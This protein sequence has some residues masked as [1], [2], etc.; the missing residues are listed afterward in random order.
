[1]PAGAALVDPLRQRAHLG[2]AIGDLV[3]EQHAAAAGLC[4]LADHHLDR[5]RLAQVVGVHAVARRKQL[6]HELRRVP[7]LLRRHAAVAGRRRGADL[8][9]S[10]P[11]RLLGGRRERAEAH[12]RDRDR[13]A[14]LQRHLGEPVS[15]HDVGV[16]ALA[17]ALERVARHARTQEEQVVEVRQ[18]PLGTEAADVVD[19][20]A[21]SALDLGDDVTVVEVALAQARMP[22]RGPVAVAVGVRAGLGCAHQYALSILKVY[23]SRADP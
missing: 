2:H 5:V 9:R 13:H 23:S 1:M 7:A 15:E 6:V 8:A 21:R 3:A 22:A 11:E 4:A 19:A 12:A 18:P 16:A 14:D 10:A 17:V 20:L